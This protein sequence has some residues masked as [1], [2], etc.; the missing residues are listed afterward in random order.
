[1]SVC[2]DEEFRALVDKLPR[3]AK[4]TVVSNSCHSG[5]L[6]EH[7]KEQI[8]ESYEESVEAGDDGGH[9]SGEEN[10]RY[11]VKGYEVEKERKKDILTSS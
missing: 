8:G 4:L 6:I 9:E 5:G 7:E 1:M 3:G 11:N 10:R 2:A